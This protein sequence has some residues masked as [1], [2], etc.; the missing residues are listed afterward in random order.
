M[1]I[2]FSRQILEK[3]PKIS[4]YIKIRPVRASLFHTDWQCLL[5]VAVYSIF[6]FLIE[7]NRVFCAVEFSLYISYLNFWHKF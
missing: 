6:V 2:E 1:K 5:F 4:Y 7:M 3:N